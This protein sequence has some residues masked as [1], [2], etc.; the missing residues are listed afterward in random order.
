MINRLWFLALIFTQPALA[1]P[2]FVEV[3][4]VRPNPNPAAPLAAVLSFKA[5]GPVTTTVTLDDGS[6]QWQVQHSLQRLA[7]LNL[8]DAITR[9]IPEVFVAHQS[10]LL[11]KSLRLLSIQAINM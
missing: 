7:E 3:P 5:N 6:R 1:A 11:V 2:A 9:Q 10:S 8:T 4:S